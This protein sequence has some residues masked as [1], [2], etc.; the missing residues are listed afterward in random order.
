MIDQ[1]GVGCGRP[2]GRRGWSTA[3]ETGVVDPKGDGVVDRKGDGVVDQKGDGVV[4]RKGDGGRT[5][6]N[7][8]VRAKWK[9]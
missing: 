7:L 6:R 8:T 4:D 5:E 3:R 1:K 9:F 2:Q